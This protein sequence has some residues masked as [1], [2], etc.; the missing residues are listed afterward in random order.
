MVVEVSII[1]PVYNEKDNLDKFISQVEK[2]LTESSTNF[3]I[4]I[5]DD[6]TSDGTTQILRNFESAEPAGYKNDLS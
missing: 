6:G 3:E 5:V 1:T 4:I 2:I